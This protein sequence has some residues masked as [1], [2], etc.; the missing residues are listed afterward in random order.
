MN[1]LGYA[2]LIFWPDMLDVAETIEIYSTGVWKQYC[3]FFWKFINMPALLV[4][5][6]IDDNVADK[7]I[8]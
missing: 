7:L 3:S 5:P 2:K 8:E 1:D 6:K 4:M